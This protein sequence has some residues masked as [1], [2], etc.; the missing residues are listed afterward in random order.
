MEVLLNKIEE[1]NIFNY[2]LPGVIFTCLLKWY[3][4]IEICYDN[5]I[6]MIFIYYFIGLIISRIGSIIIE[7]FLL[8][9]GFIKYA[10]YNDYLKATKKDKKIEQLLIVNNMY[11]TFCSMF[12]ILLLLKFVIVKFKINYHMLI[13]LGIVLYLYSYKKQT[14]FIFKRVENTKKFIKIMKKQKSNS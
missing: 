14:Q 12:I 1:Y 5:A 9:N 13:L 6:V 11:R 8:W 2:L 7:P 4:G 3:I 10:A